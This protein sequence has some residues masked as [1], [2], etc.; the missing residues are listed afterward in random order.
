[1]K[2]RKS[3][4]GT[5][6]AG[7]DKT[8][9]IVDVA[10]I[11]SLYRKG[12]F[13]PEIDRY[14]LVIMDECH[15]AASLQAQQVLRRIKAKYV[16][17]VSATP[18]RSDRLEKINYMMLG[19]IRH[20]YTSREQAMKQGI[21]L[22]VRPRFTRVVDFSEEKLEI[23]RAYELIS[24]NADRN[25][26]ITE[27][28]RS[29]IR[30]GRTP[31]ILTRL[32]KHAKLLYDEL[33]DAAQ[34]V[35]LLYGDNT[36]I[37]NQ[38][39]RREIQHIP[40]D[41]TMLLIA[42]GQK[43]GEGFDCPRLD[44]LMLASPVK[45][46]GRL[47]QYVGRL[48]RSYEGKQDVVV[49]DY[50]DAHIGIFDNQYRN[51]LA[52]Y[53]KIGYQIQSDENMGR[54]VVNAIYDRGNYTEIFER[55]MIEAEKELIISSPDIRRQK[56]TRMIELLRPRQEAGVQVTVITQD[57]ERTV[58]GDSSDVQEM[59]MEM[60]HAG[61]TVALTEDEN[62]HYAVIDKKL[63]WHGGMNLLGKEDVW[64]NLIRVESENAA[65]ELLEISHRHIASTPI[66]E[67]P[68]I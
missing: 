20:Q 18:V 16:Y 22:F 51:R 33:S 8:T 4:I 7:T 17:G 26:Q 55:D 2:K 14:G 40:G 42:T 49:F 37:R 66:N 60:R 24:E 30:D 48:N 10:M 43:I 11:G 45:F 63:V 52:A 6:Q 1:M 50:V 29:A 58:V 57:P 44:T 31:V 23:H 65:A 54:Q 15:H 13:F 27:D 61:I 38:E 59:I 39:I 64:D 12:E 53:K 3:V 36:Q 68:V 32:K 56:I 35:F 47:I 21:L 46:D 41:E 62:E 25:R 67:F 9:G 28:V 34:H 5:Y 19:P